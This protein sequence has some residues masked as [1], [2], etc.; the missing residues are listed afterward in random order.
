VHT[1][2]DATDIPVLELRQYAMKP[3]RR[4][5]LIEI[6]ERE[7]IV[8]LEEMGSIVH[9]QFRD[10]DDPDRF[11]WL[12]GFTSMRSRPDALSS[13]YTSDIWYRHRE[14]VNDTLVDSDNV[15][16]LRPMRPGSGL[17]TASSRPSSADG[18]GLIVAAIHR[19]DNEASP[20]LAEVAEAGGSP[21]GSYVT[22]RGPNNYPR[23]PIREGEDLAVWLVAF[24][25]GER[26]ERYADAQA[27]RATAVQVLR[28]APTS[29]SALQ[30]S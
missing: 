26:G 24:V 5:E 13:F 6:F 21:L 23:L 18:G 25:D 17:E 15:L 16:L 19:N 9:G 2:E 10:L 12:R 27:G 22:D 28:L 30:A 1:V 3:G 4:D 20:D 29:R 14:A 11:V 7:L 8:P